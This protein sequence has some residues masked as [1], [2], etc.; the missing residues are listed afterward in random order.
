MSTR[1]RCTEPLR[2]AL[3]ALVSA[4]ASPV[5]PYRSSA[6]VGTNGETEER[7][8]QRGQEL[9]RLLADS[10]SL[11]RDPELEAHLLAIVERLLPEFHGQF[12]VHLL[13]DVEPNAFALGNGSLYVHLG[14]LAILE[15][16]DQVAMVLAHEGAHFV[17]RHPEKRV[18]AAD[19]EKLLARTGNRG[20]GAGYTRDQEREADRVGLERLVAAGFDAAEGVRALGRLQAFQEARGSSTHSLASSHPDPGERIEDLASRL[21]PA[22][23]VERDVARYRRLVRGARAAVLREA[24]AQHQV[25][26]VLWLVEEGA[27]APS[28]DPLE[29]YALARAL[30]IRDLPEDGQRIVA[31]LREVL[32]QA[33]DHALAHMELGRRLSQADPVLAAR[34][35]RRYLELEPAA[36]DRL[37]VERE[38]ER[39]DPEERP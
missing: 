14:L 12:R 9:D 6:D 21:T 1:S 33:P 4:C 35:L 26:E 37:L 10:G 7:A 39:L 30:S 13:A 8:R 29:R 11:V 27:G 18:Q 19:F 22:P 23:P 32:D 20:L 15:D 38:I 24:L 17:L 25:D 28:D 31:I 16:D 3:V 5:E 36:S 2:L 34:H